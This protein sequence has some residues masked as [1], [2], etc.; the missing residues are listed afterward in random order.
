MNND[1]K[2]VSIFLNMTSLDDSEIPDAIL[3]G[4]KTPASAFVRRVVTGILCVIVYVISASMM[5]GVFKHFPAIKMIVACVIVYNIAR[6]TFNFVTNNLRNCSQYYRFK[7]LFR[8]EFGKK[9]VTREMAVS[10]AEERLEMERRATRLMQRP[11]SGLGV[12]QNI[13]NGINLSLGSY[14]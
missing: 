4:C 8:H 6:P 13:G 1:F 10:R 2:N 5:Q 11:R 14:Y 9:G 12:Q 7:R 3:A